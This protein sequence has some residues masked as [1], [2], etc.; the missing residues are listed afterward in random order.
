MPK[1]QRARTTDEY[2]DRLPFAQQPERISET[3]C[4]GLDVD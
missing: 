2:P 4:Q 3:H 1:I